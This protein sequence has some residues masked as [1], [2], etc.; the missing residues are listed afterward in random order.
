MY[1]LRI[2]HTMERL[3]MILEKLELVQV[4]LPEEALVVVKL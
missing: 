3:E 1:C 4:E 2:L